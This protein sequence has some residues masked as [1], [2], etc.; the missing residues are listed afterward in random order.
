MEGSNGLTW[1]NLNKEGCEL[2]RATKVRL[3]ET[4]E[5]VSCLEKKIDKLTWSL[6]GAA[7]TFA[8]AALM[9]ALNLV[10]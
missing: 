3:S 2:G 9:L 6:V 1:R 4:V 10:L 7:I 5:K 8:T